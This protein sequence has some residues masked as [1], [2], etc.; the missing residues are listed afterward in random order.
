METTMADFW[1]TKTAP[2]VQST[3]VQEGPKS[4]LMEEQKACVLCISNHSMWVMFP[5]YS[6]DVFMHFLCL[7]WMILGTLFRTQQW[8]LELW[9]SMKKLGLKLGI[10]NWSMFWLNWMLKY[11]CILMN[12]SCAWSISWNWIGFNFPQILGMTNWVKSIEAWF[13]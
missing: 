3:A 1:S 4:S 8:Y 5:P 9:T 13:D 11:A 12:W 7:F 6:F 10:F 2:T